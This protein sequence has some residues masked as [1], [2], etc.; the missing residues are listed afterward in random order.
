MTLLVHRRFQ[1][2]VAASVGVA[3]VRRGAG[4]GL[5]CAKCVPRACTINATVEACACMVEAGVGLG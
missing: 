4:V 2:C 3:H 1:P 5:M